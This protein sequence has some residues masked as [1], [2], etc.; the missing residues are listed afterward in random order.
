MIYLGKFDKEKIVSEH[1]KTN[2]IRKVWIIGENI[3]NYRCVSYS[4]CIEYDPYN[5]YR[6]S[7]QGGDLIVLNEILHTSIRNDLHYNC[8]RQYV[9]QTQHRI[10]FQ[11]MPFLNEE[12]DMAI[13]YD[14]VSQSPFSYQSNPYEQMERPE[15]Q[16]NLPTSTMV[17]NSISAPADKVKKYLSEKEKIFQKLKASPCV[18]PRQCLAA[19]KKIASLDCDL[20]DYK[21]DGEYIEHT[22]IGVSKYFCDILRKKDAIYR[23]WSRK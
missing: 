3:A 1:I 20:A 13:L 4:D 6:T 17:I 22:N 19:W 12:K 9:V 23:N 21:P 10:I 16:I 7:I 18:L 11:K 5:E 2:N 8:I 14:M 15:M